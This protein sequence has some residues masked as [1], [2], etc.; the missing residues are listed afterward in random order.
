MADAGAPSGDQ[1]SDD[2]QVRTAMSVADRIR[3]AVDAV[4]APSRGGAEGERAGKYRALC[5]AGVAALGVRGVSLTLLTPAGDSTPLAASDAVAEQVAELEFTT[6]DGPTA[7]AF[8][9]GVPVLAS[10]LDARRWPLFA[11][12]ARELGVR[13][14]FVFPMQLGAIRV[15]VL[16]LHQDQ[17]GALTPAQ[18]VGAIT[19]VRATV[20]MVLGDLDHQP[21]PEGWLGQVDGYHDHVHQ[22]TGMVLVQ[23]GITAEDALLWLRAHAFTT[24][25]PL[26]DVAADVVARR[27]SFRA[28]RHSS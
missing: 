7:E 2:E 18:L 25:R 16:C 20:T 9:V 23:L 22:A 5:A 12:A 13:S 19:L 1:P 28:E 26:A 21:S 14:I 11:P 10:A 27:L 4:Q 15:G 17:P 3:A 24:G 6:G 8:A